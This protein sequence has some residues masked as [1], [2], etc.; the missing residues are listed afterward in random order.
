M[1]NRG[2]SFQSRALPS[3]TQVRR[4]VSDILR[5]WPDA[6]RRPEDRDRERLSKEMLRRVSTWDWSD[7]TTQRVISAAMAVFDDERRARPEFAPVREF[8]LSEIATREPGAY[9]DG[10]VEIYIDSFSPGADHTRHL[11]KA[12]AKRISGLGAR[13]RNLVTALPELFRP[14]VAPLALARIMRDADD[15]FVKL[16]SIGLSS[17]HTSGLAKAAQRTFVGHLA[18]DLDQAQAR[19]KLFKWL[20]PTNGAVLQAGAGPAVEALLAPWRDRN[21][22]DALRNELSEA[23]IAAWNDPRLHSGGIWSGFDRDL[24]SV[25]LRWL[26][27]QDMKFFCDMVTATQNS[28]MWPPRRNFWLKLYEDGMIDEAWVAFGSEARRYAEQNLVRGGKTNMNRRFGRQMDRGGSTSLLIMRIG[29]KIVVDGC[30]SYKTHVFRA[31]DRKCPKLYKQQYFCDGIMRA[32]PN[33]KPHNSIPS[34][35]QWVLQHV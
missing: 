27:H 28:H 15:A 30:H 1:L 3:L 12:L 25:L 16:R 17:P 14:D 7:I 32:S 2:S 29:N 20:T 31:D 11:A 10:M 8:Y 13:H 21:P 19:A 4:S 26:T 9:L 6:I 5:R 34:W 18:P 23:I 33:S 35:S 24:R 22:P